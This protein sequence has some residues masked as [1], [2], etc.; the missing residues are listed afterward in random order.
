MTSL[1]WDVTSILHSEA[2]RGHY[3]DTDEHAHGELVILTCVPSL[4]P[5]TSYFG[6]AYGGLLCKM[7]L[8]WDVTLGQCV[9]MRMPPFVVAW[10]LSGVPMAK[11]WP[12]ASM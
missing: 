3:R 10:H 5:R 12:G 8:N 4:V 6:L 1:L 11:W 2:C 9:P 7:R